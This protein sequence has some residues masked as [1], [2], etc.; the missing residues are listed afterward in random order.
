MDVKC[1]AI[2]NII[3]G[4]DGVGIRVA[5]KLKNKLEEINISV[6]ICE[7]DTDYALST[8]NNEDYVFILDST[9]SGNNPG[10]ICFIPI[11]L[12][13]GNK[14]KIYSQHQPSLVDMIKIHKKNINGFIIGVEAKNLDFNF[15]LSDKLKN[16][17]NLICDE[18][19]E[20]IKK[21]MGE[22]NNA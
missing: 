4:D 14:F 2:G 6:I 8:I 20:F 7:T 15:E 17:F 5:E 12:Y 3:M 21:K 19:Y 1:I 22:I 9:F 13:N 11:E 10:K 18:I 16:N